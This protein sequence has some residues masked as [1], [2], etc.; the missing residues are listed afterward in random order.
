MQRCDLWVTVISKVSR[1]GSEL[2]IYSPARHVLYAHTCSVSCASPAG[3]PVTTQR[4]LPAHT[5]L[6]LE[7]HLPPDVLNALHRVCSP[8]HGMYLIRV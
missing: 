3:V 6:L 7:D 4:R 1:A 2:D 8:L 5:M